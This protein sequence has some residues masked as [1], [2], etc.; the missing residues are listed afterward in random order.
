MKDKDDLEACVAVLEPEDVR[1][2]FDLGVQALRADLST[3]CCPD[4]RALPYVGDAKWLGKIRA[5]AAARFRDDKIDISDCGAKVRKLIEEAVVA[6]GI[7]ILVKQVSLFTPEFEEQDQG[8][9]SPT[10]REASEM[11]HALKNEIH[12]KLDED[13]AFYASLRERLE[14]II[15]GPEGEAHR[16]GR[17]AQAVR[18]A[19]VRAPRPRAGGRERRAV[20]DRLRHLRPHRRA[21]AA[22]ASRSRG[23]AV[24]AQI[25]EAKKELAALLEEQL[26]A[27]GR[28][29]W[30]GR[31]R[32]TCSGRCA[33]SSSGSSAPPASHD[34]IDRPWPRASST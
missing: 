20:R 30:T 13:P 26:G 34:K 6:E 1:A 12:V 18:A 2:E 17:A 7:Q 24:R 21:E 29:S 22:D 33:G 9:R 27:P 19:A 8:A 5:T 3:W 4:P 11:E 32:T 31:T 10:R 25:D 15:A 23:H 28:Q 16:R 14:K